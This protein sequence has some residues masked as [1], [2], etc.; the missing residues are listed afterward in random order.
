MWLFWTISEAIFC[1]R[2]NLKR[3][4]CIFFLL[5]T[6][7]SIPMQL[8]KCTIIWTVIW[9]TSLLESCRLF[10]CFFFFLFSSD[11]REIQYTLSTFNF[12][13]LRCYYTIIER[14]ASITGILSF[15]TGSSQTTFLLW[16]VLD[17]IF[18]DS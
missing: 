8:F 9:R 6:D 4:T 13:S 12:T 15:E 14:R 2:E 1:S 16:K 10:F 18:R 11:A 5:R 7:I 17:D 3:L